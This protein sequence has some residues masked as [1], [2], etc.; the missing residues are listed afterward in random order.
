MSYIK[1]SKTSARAAQIKRAVRE[2]F[3]GLK[4]NYFRLFL[5]FGLVGLSGVFVNMGFLWFLTEIVG[6][7]YLA[8]SIVAVE[9]SIISNFILNNAWTFR[10]RSRGIIRLSALFRYNLVCVGAIAG[11]TTILY[12]LTTYAGF[13]YLLANLLAITVTSLWNFVMNMSWTWKLSCKG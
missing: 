2:W 6:L 7:Y 12:L 3:W 8:S 1:N 4:E 13:Y 9:A 5:R 10:D 11:S